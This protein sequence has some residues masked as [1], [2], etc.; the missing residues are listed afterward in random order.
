M[1]STPS[2]YEQLCNGTQNRAPQQTDRSRNYGFSGQQSNQSRSSTRF[3]GNPQQ[4]RTQQRRQPQQQ[5]R[6]Q[7]QQQRRQPQ[8]KQRFRQQPTTQRGNAYPAHQHSQYSYYD[9]FDRPYAYEVQYHEHF[10][11]DMYEPPNVWEILADLGLRMLEM[12][13]A[14]C[15]MEVAY[16]FDFRRFR[17]QGVWN[18][19]QHPVP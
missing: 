5:Q 17:R 9:D 19:Y 14:A 10:T 6:G 2:L 8:Q 18:G 1:A 3:R 7:P 12:G 13:I 16:F 4:Q 15:A 11:P